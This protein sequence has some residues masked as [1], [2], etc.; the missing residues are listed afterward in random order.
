MYTQEMFWCVP[1][2]NG[3]TWT[4]RKWFW[5]VHAGNGA[6]CTHRKCL[7]MYKHRKCL[8][9]YTKEMLWGVHTGNILMC[10]HRN[11]FDVYTQEKF[12]C[13]LTG[14]VLIC[15]H[16]KCLYKYKHPIYVYVCVDNDGL[17]AL[18]LE[19][20]YDGW[21]YQLYGKEYEHIMGFKDF[22]EMR[23]FIVGKRSRVKAQKQE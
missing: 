10:T 13:V 6:R 20:F 17:H 18:G 1:T 8:Y 5:R 14:N 9:V 21:R 22:V 16:R 4:H 15:T 2:G 3:L 23:D 19:A 11:C 7:Y 12:W